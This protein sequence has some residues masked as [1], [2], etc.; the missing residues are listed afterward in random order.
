[1][2]Y[3]ITGTCRRCGGDRVVVVATPDRREV[4]RQLKRLPTYYCP[5]G[6]VVG[7]KSFLAAYAWDFD[8]PRP[9]NGNRRPMPR[10]QT[11]RDISQ[12]A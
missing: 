9:R 6:H 5:G 3:E 10:T 1:M 2:Q 11:T 8:H 7:N 12:F 4:E